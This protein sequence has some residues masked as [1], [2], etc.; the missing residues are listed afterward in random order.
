[1]SNNRLISA[2]SSLICRLLLI[3]TRVQRPWA[4]HAL[5][6]SFLGPSAAKR[7]AFETL[8]PA[9]HPGTGGSVVMCTG[10]AMKFE[11]G[12]SHLLFDSTNS[13]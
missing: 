7:G 2:L 6:P 11:K 8:S 1:M 10:A 9:L 4:A 3:I 12:F 5:G 13:E